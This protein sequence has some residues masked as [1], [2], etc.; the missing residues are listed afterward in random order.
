MKIIVIMDDLVIF[1]GHSISGILCG[2]KSDIGP[3]VRVKNV[4]HDLVWRRTEWK[5][6][7]KP[8]S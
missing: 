4:I 1:C 7:P 3:C 6:N 2:L 5:S 8:S